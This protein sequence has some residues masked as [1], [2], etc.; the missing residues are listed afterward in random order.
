MAKRKNC[1][2][3]TYTDAGELTKDTWKCSKKSQK[4]KLLNAL[5]LDK[6]WAETK[7]IKEMVNRGGGL[8][9]NSILKLE[10]ILL[11]NK[12]GKVKINWDKK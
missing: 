9:A 8:P 11:K 10:R 2:K 12:G 4:V 6:S 1:G 7:T 3:K 5:G